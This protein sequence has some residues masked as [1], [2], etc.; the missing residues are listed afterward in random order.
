[1]VAESAGQ[2]VSLF[3]VDAAGEL[4]NRRRL[5]LPEGYYPDGLCLDD[6]GGIWVSVL[7]NGVIRITHDGTVTHKITLEDGYHAYACMFGGADKRTLHLCTAGPYD[8]E[9]ARKTRMGRIETLVPG[10]TG[11]GLD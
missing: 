2:C 8:N 11:A 10:F 5:T 4:S 9:L 7:W 6:A 1:M 3:D